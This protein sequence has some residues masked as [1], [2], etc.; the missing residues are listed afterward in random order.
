[1]MI[2][3]RTSL[4][5]MYSDPSVFLLC[6]KRI[7]SA[8][9]SDSGHSRPAQEEG[10][11]ADF[12]FIV[13]PM[14]LSL[15]WAEEVDDLVSAG[16]Q[17]LR[18]QPPVAAGPERLGAQE[19]GRC[20]VGESRR[21]RGLPGV[22]SHTCGVASKRC[23]ADAGELVLA[24]LSAEPTAELDGVAV[25]DADVREGVSKRSLVELR[26]ATGRRIAAH[27]DQRPD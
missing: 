8:D 19:A 23:D 2:T 21:E 11:V 6:I 13:E 12:S 14:G 20:R 24:G 16:C 27:V 9:A 3:S 7:A 22:G 1:M 17:E 10:S 15:S 4:S 25:G 18:D 26:V 5:V